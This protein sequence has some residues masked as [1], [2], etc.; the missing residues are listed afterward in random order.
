MKQPKVDPEI[1]QRLR[2]WQQRRPLE[3]RGRGEDRAEEKWDQV[4]ISEAL[5][6]S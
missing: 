2:K 5:S 6:S 1:L 3:E 4:P